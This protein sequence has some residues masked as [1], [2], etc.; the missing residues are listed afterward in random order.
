M[1]H[2]PAGSQQQDREFARYASLG[3]QFGFSFLIFCGL[4]YAFDSWRETQP[5]GLLVGALGGA[6]GA[7]YSLYRATTTRET[8]TKRTENDEK[9]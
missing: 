9:F 6:V 4:G 8:K 5:Y 1:S 7:S 2:D 3:L